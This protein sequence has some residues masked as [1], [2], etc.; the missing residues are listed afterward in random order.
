MAEQHV[1]G[2]LDSACQLLGCVR[3]TQRAISSNAW[4]SVQGSGFLS[5]DS[6]QAQKWALN[7][8]TQSRYFKFSIVLRKS[9]MRRREER[10]D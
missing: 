5:Q 3:P 10:Q 6:C 7:A 4:G 8:K 2:S 1:C 9:W